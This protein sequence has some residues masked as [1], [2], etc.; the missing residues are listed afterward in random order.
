[1]N[2]SKSI[3]DEKIEGSFVSS[4]LK[5]FLGNSAHFPMTNLILEALTENPKEYFFEPDPY[6]LIV[7]ALSQSFALTYLRKKKLGFTFLGNFVGPLV[8]LLMEA[9]LEGAKFYTAPQH[10]AYWYFSLFIGLFQYLKEKEFLNIAVFFEV[11]ENVV[12]TLIPLCMY[13]LFEAKGNDFLFS[14]PGF[15]NDPAHVFLTIVLTLLGLLIGF[16]QAQN[17]LSKLKLKTLAQQLRNY[18]SWSLGKQVLNLAV[19]DEKIFQIKRVERAILFLDIRGFT[20]W[21]EKETPENVVNMLNEFYIEAE[22]ILKSYKVLKMKYTAD[23][24]MIVFENYDQ[25]AH[26]SLELRDNL[27]KHL[28]LKN[29]TVGGGVH[30]GPVVEG[31]IGSEDHK[32]FD[33]MGDTVNTAKRLCESAKGKEILI[34]QKFIE[35]S[36]GKAFT[37]EGREVVLKGKEKTHFVYPL[38]KYFS[39]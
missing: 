28:S 37:T 4:L 39:H 9:P 7:T 38:E 15:F 25:A 5:E 12:R 18:S 11:G 20:K 26:A 21:S 27:N 33:V 23:E 10:H 19:S 17:T 30:F 16:S 32:L 3:I 24:I 35:I 2:E 34:S 14:L 1:M 13:I 36:E 22:K 29:L 31:L 8:Y 6:I